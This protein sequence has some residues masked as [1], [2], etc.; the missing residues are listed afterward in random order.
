MDAIHVIEI[1]TVT[2]IVIKTDTIKGT[3]N[4]KKAVS[5]M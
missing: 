2:V 1:R 5:S 3:V 4:E